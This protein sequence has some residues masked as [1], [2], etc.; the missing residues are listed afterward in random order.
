MIPVARPTTRECPACAMDAPADAA[1]CPMCGYEFPVVKAGLG[2]SAWLMV[3]LML[4]FA[5]PL[6][7]WLFG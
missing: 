2:L 3:G 4:L 5:L 7:A 6:L 1:E